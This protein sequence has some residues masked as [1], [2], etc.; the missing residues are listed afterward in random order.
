MVITQLN[1]EL[2]G[3]ALPIF[4]VTALGGSGVGKTIFMSFMYKALQQNKFGFRIRADH[5]TELEMK[6]NIINLHRNNEFPVGTIGDEK[7][8]IFELFFQNEPKAI[9]DWVDYRG[10]AMMEAEESE[11]TQA[12]MKRIRES[13]CVM[14]MI[15]LTEVGRRKI[16]SM[17]AR[18]FAGTLTMSN[19][20]LHALRTSQTLRSVIFVRT[21]SDTVRCENN[22]EEVDW[23]KACE[24]LY[25]H[26]GEGLYQFSGINYTA[27]I[28]VSS[29]GRLESDGT[30]F[31]DDPHN[32][33]WT[34]IL[35]LAFMLEKDTEV[36]DAKR[37]EAEENL[38]EVTPGNL[39]KFWRDV[40]FQKGKTK[41][42]VEASNELSDLT[43]E[44]FAGE[45]VFKKMLEQVPDDEIKIFL[46]DE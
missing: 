37:K 20:T 41:K 29:S 16:D 34:L 15:D 2:D 31:G 14:W 17:M 39:L 18:E 25:S 32:V 30:L 1:L 22:N 7:K 43:R 6:E 23:K 10:G 26:L 8:Y 11:E 12:L 42:E 5:D 27:L 3:N 36:V 45:E 28:P 38:R 4:K 19:L 44:V 40:T 21:K 24:E 46:K 9:I 35:A 33:E 13:H